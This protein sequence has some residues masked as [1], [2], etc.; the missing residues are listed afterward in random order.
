[1]GEFLVSGCKK[2]NSEAEQIREFQEELI[3][4]VHQRSFD[5]IDLKAA[6]IFGQNKIL[7][8]SV[9]SDIKRR[10]RIHQISDQNIGIQ[11]APVLQ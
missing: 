10:P 8:V 4:V 11:V 7:P 6:F 2:N 3:R 5:A 1:M 9:V